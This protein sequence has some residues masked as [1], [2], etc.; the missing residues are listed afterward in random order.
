MVKVAFLGTGLLGS[1][2]V[3]RMLKHGDR[4]TVWNRTVAKAQ[5]LAAHGAIVAATPEEAVADAEF[6][7]LALPDDG[8][9][10]QMLVRLVSHL[11]AGVLVID[12]TTTS[13]AGTK[14][15]LERMA[16]NGVAFIHAPVFMSPQMCRDG[17][18]MILVAG[19]TPLFERAHHRLTRMTGHVWFLGER[20]DHAAAFKLFGN[21]LLFVLTAGIADVFA[22]AA[23]LG[24][25]FDDAVG[26]FEKFPIGGLVGARAAKMASGDL[27][28]TFELTMARKDVRLMIEAAG[29]QPLTVLPAIARKMDAAIAEGHGHQDMAAIVAGLLHR[30]AP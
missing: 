27:T 17:A 11:P 25:P 7:H 20:P 21:S 13:P 16:G 2:M 10:D 14:E 8:V 30:G 4:V 24:V 26:L 18:G 5:A 22:M 12:H 15:R 6:V 1:G 23:H 9:V 3:E 29:D 19:P 28:A